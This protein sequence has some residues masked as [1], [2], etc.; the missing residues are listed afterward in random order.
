M[1]SVFT[2]ED[3]VPKILHLAIGA[4]ILVI[5]VETMKRMGRVAR[6]IYEIH[7]GHEEELRGRREILDERKR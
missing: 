1:K 7:R 5:S 2:C 3:L 6:G 4:A